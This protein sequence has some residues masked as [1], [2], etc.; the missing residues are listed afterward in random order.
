MIDKG[1]RL[2]NYL[3]DLVIIY[4][5]WTISYIILPDI[6]SDFLVFYILMFFYYF[7]LELIF[8]QTVG[9]M[10]TKTKVVNKND[11]KASVLQLGI[12]SSLRLIPIDA[13]SY[14]FGTERGFHDILS[15][16]RL[17]KSD[18]SATV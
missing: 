17:V 13:F 10:V 16:T 2:T 12:R 15:S 8:Q 7:L 6:A 3:I 4:V 5:L 14:L 18:T 9:K 1:L 11:T